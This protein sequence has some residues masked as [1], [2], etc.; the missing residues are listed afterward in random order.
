VVV[1]AEEA[2]RF[3]EAAA[4]L[5]HRLSW[6]SPDKVARAVTRAV[7]HDWAI[8]PVNPD[9]WAGYLLS[10]LSPGLVRA[11]VRVG[12]FE[13]AA[14]TANRLLPWVG[15]ANPREPEPVGASR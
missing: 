8:V 2:A 1:S 13:R 7:A 15:R 10:R 14:S 12:S 9:V 4:T 3:V 11:L 5:Q 6:T